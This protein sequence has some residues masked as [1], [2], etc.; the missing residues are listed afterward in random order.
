MSVNLETQLTIM[1]HNKLM[2]RTFIMCS[3]MGA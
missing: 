1:K 2:K 3:Y